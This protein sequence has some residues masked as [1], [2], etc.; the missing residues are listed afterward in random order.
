MAKESAAPSE[1]KR[2]EATHGPYA[3]AQID[4]PTAD[5]DSAIADG[6]AFDPYAEVDPN[7]NAEPKEITADDN[8]RA[9]AAAE[10]AARKFRGEAEPPKPAPARSAKAAPASDAADRTSDSS[11]ADA[12]YQTRQASAASTAK[13][14]AAK[15]KE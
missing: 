3:G 5:A 10:T 7:P 11:G 14:A 15:A 13:P 1:T 2:I 4:V 12:G 6:W 8:A 9:L